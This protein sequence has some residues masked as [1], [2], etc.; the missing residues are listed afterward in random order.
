MG[1]KKKIKNAIFN[2]APMKKRIVIESNPAF[3]CNTW[4]MYKEMLRRGWNKKYEIVWS[5]KNLES[6]S[7]LPHDENVKCIEHDPSGYFKKLKF[8]WF[9]ARSCCLICSNRF[10]TKRNKKQL[11]IYLTHGSQ[12]KHTRGIHEMGDRCDFCLYQAEMFREVTAYEVNCPVE[13]MVCLGSP[14]NDYFF[15]KSDSITRLI[16]DLNGRKVIIWLPTFRQGNL[17]KLGGKCTDNVFPFG[18]PVITQNEDFDRLNDALKKNDVIMLFKPH[19]A[20]DMS[21][22]KTR[23][24]SNFIVIDD[25]MLAQ[26]HIHLYELMAQTDAL[27][28]DYSSVYFDYLLIDKPCGLTIDDIEDFT[29]V[30]GFAHDDV[31]SLLVGKNIANMGDMENF[32]RQIG[33][34]EDDMLQKRIEVKNRTNFYQ[35]G[36]SSERVCDFV[37]KWLS[38]N[39]MA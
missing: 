2:M 35:D 21:Y 10:L 9:L 39:N 22:V 24:L 30:R 26:K 7:E 36:H 37:E 4:P 8:Q 14:R 27:I 3:A 15:S 33:A 31:A 29:A 18:I 6:Y 28:T 34:G 23:G 5:V 38:E 12:I 32:V 11:S 17:A 16:P 25:S 19:P 1:L 20:Q 13:K